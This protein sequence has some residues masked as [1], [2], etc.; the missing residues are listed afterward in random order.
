MGWGLFSWHSGQ[1][2]SVLTGFCYY[3]KAQHWDHELALK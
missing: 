3:R 2:D 1:L